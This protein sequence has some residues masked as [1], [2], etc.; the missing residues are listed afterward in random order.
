MIRTVRQVALE[1]ARLAV[2]RP[3]TVDGLVRPVDAVVVLQI[4]TPI[5][6]GPGLHRVLVSHCLQ[7]IQV[8]EVRSRLGK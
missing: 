8:R 2:A 5:E 3:E 6:P 4:V 7:R 1:L